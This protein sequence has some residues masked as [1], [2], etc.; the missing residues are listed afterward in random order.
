[1]AK[2]ERLGLDKL[3][4]IY[5]VT[6]EICQDYARLTD[7]YSLATGDKMFESIPSD[8][9]RMI[10]ER[11]EFFN[12]RNKLKELLKVKIREQFNNEEK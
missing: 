2:L 1:M 6:N 9:S 5:S 3:S 11:Q 7:G 4:L 10:D 12:Y 8:I